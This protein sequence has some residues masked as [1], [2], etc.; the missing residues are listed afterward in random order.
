M[1]TEV[2][3][4]VPP[5]PFAQAAQPQATRDTPNT[6]FYAA[7][8]RCTVQE[9]ETFVPKGTRAADLAVLFADRQP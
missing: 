4:N 7:P 2:S 5:L 8:P 1:M 6:A 3:F 9:N